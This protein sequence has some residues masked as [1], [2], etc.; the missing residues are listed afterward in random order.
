LPDRFSIFMVV[1]RRLKMNHVL[2]DHEH[3]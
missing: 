1:G 2:G 3:L